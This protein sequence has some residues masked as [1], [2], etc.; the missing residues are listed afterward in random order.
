MGKSST[1]YKKGQPSANPKGR[2]K[3]RTEEQYLHATIAKVTL[4][5]WHEV[6]SKAVEDA[7]KGDRDAR[8]FLASY[9]IGNPQSHTDHTTQG[10]KIDNTIHITLSNDDD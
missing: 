8:K 9:L 3:K 6:I 10:D 4:S 7:K 1:S 5:D 2:P